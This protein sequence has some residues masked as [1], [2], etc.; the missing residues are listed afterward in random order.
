[1]LGS[2]RTILNSAQRLQLTTLRWIGPASAIA[3]P[4]LLA[5]YLI[6]HFGLPTASAARFLLAGVVLGIAPGYLLLRHVVR[7]EGGSPF[8]RIV[9]AGLIGCLLM[10]ALWYLA[11]AAGVPWLFWIAAAGMIPLAMRAARW[12]HQTSRR[13][14][15]L[16]GPHEALVLWTAL[17]LTITWSYSLSIVEEREGGVVVM[18]YGDH[19]LHGFL[20]AELARA[21]PPERLPFLAGPTTWVYHNLP[22]VSTDLWRRATGLAPREAYYYLALTL[23]YLLISLAAYLAVVHRFGRAAGIAAMIGLLAVV[24]M[25]PGWLP[26]TTLGG[27]LDNQ[28]MI[29]LHHSYPTAWGLVGVLLILYLLSRRRR[30]AV[31][32]I[33]LAAL[34]SALLLFYKA[35]F[36]LCAAPAV[37]LIAALTWLPER[38]WR[39]LALCLGTQA[40]VAGVQM[41]RLRTSDLSPQLDFIPTAFLHWW[42]TNDGQVRSLLGVAGWQL[43]NTAPAAAKWPVVLLT[44]WIARFTPLCLA[45]GYWAFASRSRKMRLDSDRSEE[46]GATA[47]ATSLTLPV[48][49]ERRAWAVAGSPCPETEPPVA[50]GARP[51]YDRLI[52]LLLAGCA[53]GFVLFPVQRGLEWNFSA[54]LLYLVH[55][56]EMILL[57]VLG[58]DLA[59]RLWR[60]GCWSRVA[61]ALI[62]LPLAADNLSALRVQAIWATRTPNG[63]V[64]EDQYACLNFIR[65]HTPF[66]AVLLQ[67]DVFD[68]RANACVVAERRLVLENELGWRLYYDTS[69]HLRDVDHF[70]RTADADSALDVL[71]RYDVDYLLAKDQ[72]PTLPGLTPSLECVFRSG[73]YA[74]YRVCPRPTEHASRPDHRHVITDHC[75]KQGAS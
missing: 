67:P 10:P 43:I 54:H 15:C 75:P 69:R 34:L 68:L 46:G 57:G 55:A 33:W 62:L 30:P 4:L 64:S 28:L 44:A 18:P 45:L 21:T 49:A 12:R 58:L 73:P 37:A 1:V 31:G 65:R 36:A 2:L 50:S 48:P 11:C 22:D 74:V 47:S 41:L 38:R 39:P 3:C 5:A 13:L 63:R 7:L 9:A 56:L 72:T 24:R 51:Q 53:A 61:L 14:R 19:I 8:T 59:R 71:Q 40:I 52:L 66:N 25:W 70:Y 29:Y 32:E 27:L 16:V 42:W 20:A 35:N 26:E 17:L 60:R 23:R 6:L